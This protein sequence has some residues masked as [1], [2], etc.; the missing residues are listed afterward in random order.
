LH[1]AQIGQLQELEQEQER[2]GVTGR[3]EDSANL[4]TALGESV[5]VLGG[6]KGFE[7]IREAHG[8]AKRAVRGHRRQAQLVLDTARQLLAATQSAS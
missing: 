6:G 1:H 4:E 8:R 5:P 3:L 7:L 2:T